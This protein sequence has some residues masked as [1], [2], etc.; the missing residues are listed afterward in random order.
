MTGRAPPTGTRYSKPVAS[1]RT[2]ERSAP[3]F[4]IVSNSQTAARRS[5]RALDAKGLMLANGDRWDC[6]VEIDEAGGMHALNKK[7]TG[8]TLAATR[9]RLADIDRGQLPSVEQ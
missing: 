3:Q 2:F 9:D 7:L 1:A 6:F 8:L 4:S 5:R